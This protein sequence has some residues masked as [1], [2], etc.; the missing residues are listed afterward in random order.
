MTRCLVGSNDSGTGAKDVCA[1]AEALGLPRPGAK[2]A[3]AA[4]ANGFFHPKVVHI[5]RID[6]SQAAYVGSANLTAS[7]VLGRHIEAGVLLDS[8]YGDA[9]IELEKI[10]AAIDA[11]FV[12]V[13]EGCFHIEH[14]G[15]VEDLVARGVLAKEA[16]PDDSRAPV[17][18]SAKGEMPAL[19][20]LS[21]LLKLLTNISTSTGSSQQSSSL[22]LP[23][24]ALTGNLETAGIPVYFLMELSKNRIG[25]TSIQ[26]DIGLDAFKNFFGGM[27]G[28]QVDIQVNTVAINGSKVPKDRQ[29]VDVKSS[30]YRIEIDFVPPYP[31][32]GR[33]VVTFRR[34]SPQ[35][36]DCLLLVP[37]D[38]GY[39]K[40]RATLVAFARPVSDRQMKRATIDGTQL[41]SVWVDC[42][43]L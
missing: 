42:P 34:L 9:A 37:T 32:N 14:A 15:A 11:W 31:A 33:P 2:L 5:R 29:L 28:G 13:R 18:K 19:P 30:N 6:G 22:Q 3:V 4:F 17:R 7:G 39:A 40:A 27:V 8:A 16:E 41:R 43:L 1:L 36:F 38:P 26:A 12:G 20:T 25:R 23:R 24:G 35:E 10:A 21:P